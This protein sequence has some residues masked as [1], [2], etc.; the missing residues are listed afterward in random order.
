[1]VMIEG[2]K[3]I[4]EKVIEEFPGVEIYNLKLSKL[5]NDY[6][7]QIELDNLLDPFGSVTIETCEN[8]SKKFIDILDE[9][10]QSDK[11]QYSLPI[12]LEIDNYTLEVSSAG[13]ERE[14]KNLGDLERFKN[15]PLKIRYYSEQKEK[16]IIGKFI[17]KEEDYFNFE[18]YLTRKQKK[19]TK[20][21]SKLNILKIKMQDIIKINL[22]LDI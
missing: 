2:L 5:H 17:N 21:K 14:I 16:E 8:F 18:E 11:L 12:D 6:Y 19:Q 9:K 10:L 7:I 22:F 20:G 15:F 4:S 13:A 1:M 3:K